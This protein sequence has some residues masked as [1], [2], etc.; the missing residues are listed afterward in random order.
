MPFVKV[1]FHPAE[2]EY[3]FL[4][5]FSEDNHNVFNLG[6]WVMAETTLGQDL[7]LITWQGAEKPKDFLTEEVKPLLRSAK[8][9]EI[10]TRKEQKQKV[11]QYLKDCEEACQKKDLKMKLVDAHE[12]LD[13]T[14]LTFYFISE[15][16]VDFRDLVRDLIS[17]F[18]KKIRLQQIGVRDEA[19]ICGDYGP[20]GLPLCC[21]NWLKSLGN[22]NAEYIKDQDLMHRGNER[23]SGICGRLKCCLRY[24]EEAYKYG[25]D[26]LPE[27][28]DEIKTKAGLGRVTAV[29]PLKQTVDLKIDGSIVEYP[30]LEGKL[31][32]KEPGSCDGCLSN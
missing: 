26:K 23:L 15:N 13:G 29:H 30:Y 2:R 3:L 12:S 16:R 1:Q 25:L 28:G 7:A 20:C 31:C 32:Q 11:A 14:R 5:E 21:K 22:V 19:K 9:E 8:T 4:A 6:D 27:V 24:E 17:K 18:H 10:K